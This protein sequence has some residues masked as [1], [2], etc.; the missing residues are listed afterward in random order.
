MRMG[1]GPVRGFGGFWVKVSFFEAVRC[2]SVTKHGRTHEAL[3][4]SAFP[5]GETPLVEGNPGG[6]F[7]NVNVNI[8]TAINA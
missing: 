2:I 1:T 7:I 8:V 3:E 6:P 4:V 5:S